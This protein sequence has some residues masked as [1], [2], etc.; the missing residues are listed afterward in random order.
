MTPIGDDGAMDTQTFDV[1]LG[2]EKGEV[3]SLPAEARRM[4]IERPVRVRVGWVSPFIA[5]ERQ[6]ALA[7][8]M[9]SRGRS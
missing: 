9:D 8:T 7:C 6:D 1:G 4:R 3:I 2:R 5:V